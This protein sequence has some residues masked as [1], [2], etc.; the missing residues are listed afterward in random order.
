MNTIIADRITCT[1]VM[2]LLSDSTPNPRFTTDRVFLLLTAPKAKY[3][4]IRKSKHNVMKSGVVQSRVMLIRKRS[5]ILK[6]VVSTARTA[7]NNIVTMPALEN[8]S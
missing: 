7:I 4:S 2:N 8:P 6:I 1:G 3:C 5:E